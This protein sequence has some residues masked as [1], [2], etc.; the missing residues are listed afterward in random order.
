M[1]NPE[2]KKCHHGIPARHQPCWWILLI[3]QWYSMSGSLD[4]FACHPIQA[5]VLWTKGSSRRSYVSGVSFMRSPW[6]LDPPLGRSH[7]W[8]REM[9]SQVMDSDKKTTAPQ[10]RYCKENRISVRLLKS[11]SWLVQGCMEL[12]IQL[13]SGSLKKWQGEP[14]GDFFC[15]K[16]RGRLR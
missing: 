6:H 13:A 2:I 10:Y 12:N 3:L 16:I 8:N 1:I 7:R 4:P 14:A 5:D 15:K 9:F 11:H